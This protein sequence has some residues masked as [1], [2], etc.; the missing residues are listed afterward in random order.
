METL[1]THQ[2]R[3]AGL[4]RSVRAA[5]VLPSLFALA[6]FVIGQPEVAG[7]TIFGTFAH[8]V[9]VNYDRAWRARFV[10]SA[11][12]TGLGAIMVSLGTLASANVWLADRKSV[13]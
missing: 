4:A 6:L 7:F 12:L 2:R 8:L 9:M 5:I 3:L 1:D 10:E 13:V 11:M